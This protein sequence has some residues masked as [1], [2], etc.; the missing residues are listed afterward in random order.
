MTNQPTQTPGCLPE[1][2]PAGRLIA[3]DVLHANACPNAPWTEKVKPASNEQ[4]AAYKAMF[5]GF[6]GW[7]TGSKNN[8]AFDV[9]ADIIHAL[10]AR[11][12]AERARADG[13]ESERDNLAAELVSSGRVRLHARI[14][15]LEA[16]IS[17][18]KQLCAKEYDEQI[19]PAS[20]SLDWILG[21]VIAGS[22][23]RISELEAAL[24]EARKERN[25]DLGGGE[26][27]CCDSPSARLGEAKAAPIGAYCVE[28]HRVL[29]STGWAD[30]Q[31]RVV[32]LIERR[33]KDGGAR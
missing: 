24:A 26:Y 29:R 1:C 33:R 28:H 23:R 4:V 17:R 16:E 5:Q 9:H 31:N 21:G 27:P 8:R 15:E 2:S 13:A 18:S 11:I 12:D 19:D 14:A 30:Y 7:L 3:G 25:H 22:R 20:V 32:D 10:I 6:D